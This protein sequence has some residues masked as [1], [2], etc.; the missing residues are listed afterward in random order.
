MSYK[1][2]D[3]FVIEITKITNAF[4]GPIYWCDD[5][6][7]PLAL[8]EE[9]LNGLPRLVSGVNEYSYNKGWTD[10]CEAFMRAVNVA[11]GVQNE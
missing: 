7:T 4:S 3:K 1:V 6:D 8:S 11:S 9:A 5:F 10:A 2:G